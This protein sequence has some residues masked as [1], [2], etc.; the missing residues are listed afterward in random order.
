MHSL[1]HHYYLAFYF[2]VGLVVTL[3]ELMYS[4]GIKG[5]RV[6]RANNAGSELDTSGANP[7]SGQV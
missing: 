5:V 4:E 3:N 6:E 2:I 1:F 7:S